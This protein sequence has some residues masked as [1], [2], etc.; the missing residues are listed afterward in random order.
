MAP[1]FITRRMAKHLDHLRQIAHL[2]FAAPAF[3]TWGEDPASSNG[4]NAASLLSSHRAVHL[5]QERLQLLGCNRSNTLFAASVCADEINHEHGDVC[6]A[7]EQHWGEC[8]ALGGLGGVPFTGL[9]GFRAFRDHV[10]HD[11]NLFILF[12]PHVGIAPDGSV[13]RYAR[14]GQLIT[15]R[16]SGTCGAAVAAMRL[17]REAAASTS[18]P[19]VRRANASTDPFAD[20]MLDFQV[21]WLKARLGAQLT[22]PLQSGPVSRLENLC[23]YLEEWKGNHGERNTSAAIMRS[24]YL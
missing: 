8:F 2:H 21:Q 20:P 14:R 11:G 23:R 6:T 5:A 3:A 18:E 16:L 17:A 19:L 24:L 10:P 22:A 15:D 4:G 12:A 9:G 7:F 1:H 13:G